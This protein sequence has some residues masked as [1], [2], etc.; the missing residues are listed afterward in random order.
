MIPTLAV[1]F[2]IF[3]LKKIWKFRYDIKLNTPIWFSVQNFKFKNL[4]EKLKK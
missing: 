4:I 1:M 2:S 3:F